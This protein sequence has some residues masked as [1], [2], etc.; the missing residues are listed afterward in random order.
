MEN[1]ECCDEVENSS[2]VPSPSQSVAS[3]SSLQ[4]QPC[5]LTAKDYTP[6]CNKGNRT[7]RRE[8]DHIEREIITELKKTK[9]STV[10]SDH[11]LLLLS[12]LPYIRDM[13]EMELMDL[14][15]EILT[16]IKKIKQ[17]RISKVPNYQKPKHPQQSPSPAGSNSSGSNT[18]LYKMLLISRLRLRLAVQ[19]STK[20]RNMCFSVSRL[21]PTQTPTKARKKV[22]LISCLRVRCRIHLKHKIRLG[23]KWKIQKLT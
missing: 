18:N 23:L 14:Q 4:A 12:F 7:K 21:P 10:Q 8:L 20:T 2:E 17:K 16:T 22:F 11:E 1:F 6:V 5:E 13:R 15:M 19:V 9:S 3:N